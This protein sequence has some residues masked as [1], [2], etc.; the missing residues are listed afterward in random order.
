[1]VELRVELVVFALALY[2]TFSTPVEGDEVV[3]VIVPVL[4]TDVKV[5]SEGLAVT[6]KLPLPPAPGKVPDVA[7]RP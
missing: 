1:M 3:T 7:L 6:L 2:A 5:Q 4:V